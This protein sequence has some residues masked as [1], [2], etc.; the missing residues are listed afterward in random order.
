M[1]HYLA[2]AHAFVDGYKRIAWV[3]A[4]TYLEIEGFGL[5]PIADEEIV[6]LVETVAAARD[7][8]EG[9]IA[10]WFAERLI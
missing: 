1:L 7:K 4:S 3:W 2:K 10:E 6:E 5:G 8:E 9:F